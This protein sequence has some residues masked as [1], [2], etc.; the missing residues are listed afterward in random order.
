MKKWYILGQDFWHVG[1]AIHQKQVREALG[2][3]CRI[4]QGA[5]G[6][7]QLQIFA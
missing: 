5:D 1:A 3:V 2:D 4:R 6:L 7:W